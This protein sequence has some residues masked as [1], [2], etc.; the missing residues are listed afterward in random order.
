MAELQVPRLDF[1]ALAELPQ[2]YRQARN[3]TNSEL[4]LAALGR[5]EITRE[6]AATQLMASDPQRAMSLATLGNNERDFKFRESEAAR[7]QENANKGF[8]LQERQINATAGNTA[9]Q[10]ALARAQFE[11]QKSQAL[12]P[13]IRSTDDGLVSIDSQRNAATV[14]PITGRPNEAAPA[15]MQPPPGVNRKAW[16]EARSKQLGNIDD[17][18]VMEADKAVQAGSHALTALDR[19][20]SLSQSAYSGPFAQQRGYYASQFGGQRGTDTELLTNTVTNT[21]LENLRATFGGNPTEGERKILLD[22]Q[23]AASQAPQV[24]EQIYR[25]ARDAAARRIEFNRKMAEDMRSGQYL[26]PQAARQQPQQAQQ[27]SGVPQAA[28]AALQQNPALREQF[29]AKYGAGASARV[30]GQ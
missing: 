4:T 30:L 23:G 2:A 26:L 5:G 10:Q 13:E 28:V 27:T 6:Q 19:A 15:V 22:V 17:K 11:F 16:L 12:R 18:A 9:A 8:A 7:A 20:L 14:L 29:D 3:Q 24:R 25:E 1:S 21:A